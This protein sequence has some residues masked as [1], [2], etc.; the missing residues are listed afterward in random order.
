MQFKLQPDSFK[1]GKH[2]FI[3]L[4]PHRLNLDGL[5]LGGPARLSPSAPDRESP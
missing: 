2:E 3:A 4:V 1:D 5:A